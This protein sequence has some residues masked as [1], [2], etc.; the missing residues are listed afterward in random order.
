VL[1]ILGAATPAR[2]QEAGAESVYRLRLAPDLVTIGL[3]AAAWFGPE[4]FLDQLVTPKCPCN[5]LD[6]PAIDRPAL[7]RSSRAARTASNVAVSV[8]LVVP[9]AL[10][11]LDVR[12]RGGAWSTVGEDLVVMGEALLVD[13]ALNELVKI[14]VQRPRP[15]T[16]DGQELG[17][18]DSYLS[19]YSAHSSTAFAMGMAYATTFSRR[20]P[21]SGYRYLVYGAV[22]AGG[23]TTGVLRVLAGKHFPSDVLIGALVGSAVGIAVPL[24]HRRQELS[25]AVAPGGVALVGVF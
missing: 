17:R 15:F 8:V 1:L 21:Q 3:S 22:I 16:Y 20:H 12:L 7:G 24:L 6:V 23:G 13:G 4:L 5:R 2:A 14:A 11:L 9:A 10:D 25:L 18:S 19:F